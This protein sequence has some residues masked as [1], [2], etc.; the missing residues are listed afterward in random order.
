MKVAQ[1]VACIDVKTGYSSSS[2]VVYY[3]SKSPAERKALPVA[4]SRGYFLSPKKSSREKRLHYWVLVSNLNITSSL[5]ACLVVAVAL[6]SQYTGPSTIVYIQIAGA[7]GVVTCI[8]W[9][10]L[11][12]INANARFPD[13]FPV[14]VSTLSSVKDLESSIL[15]DMRQ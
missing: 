8:S 3:L 6:A 4:L 12:C 1:V 13:F 5:Q 11:F 2:Y 15:S 7:L 10:F 9:M 14:L